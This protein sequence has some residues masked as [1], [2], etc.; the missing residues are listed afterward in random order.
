MAWISVFRYSKTHWKHFWYFGNIDIRYQYSQPCEIET[1]WMHCIEMYGDVFVPL[2]HLDAEAFARLFYA[3]VLFATQLSDVSD[4]FVSEAF[5]VPAC[6]P[7]AHFPLLH[8]VCYIFLTLGK[9]TPSYSKA[10]RC[11]ATL[12]S[13]IFVGSV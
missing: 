7:R 1:N 6:C 13:I 5:N 9:T 3:H 10:I 2:R 8:I 11:W 4:Q 12:Q